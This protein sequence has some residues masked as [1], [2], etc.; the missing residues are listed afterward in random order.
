MFAQIQSSDKS[1]K[2]ETLYK[3]KYVYLTE[4]ANRRYVRTYT[5]HIYA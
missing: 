3:E 2:D 1:N 5:I 4:R